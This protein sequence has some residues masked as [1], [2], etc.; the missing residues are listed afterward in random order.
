MMHTV[1][2]ESSTVEQIGYKDKK[3]RSANTILTLELKLRKSE[4][5]MYV[6]P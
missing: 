1:G 2:E 3:A 5:L 4:I 6:R